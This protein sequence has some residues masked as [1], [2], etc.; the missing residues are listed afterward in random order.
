MT[1]SYSATLYGIKDG[2]KE[3]I[4]DSHKEEHFS[5]LVPASNY[6]GQLLWET[7]DKVLYGAVTTME[8]FKAV[9]KAIGK[10]DKPLTWTTPSNMSCYYAP[11]KM[12]SKAYTVMHNRKKSAY[13]MLEATPEIDGKK[14]TSSIA[15]NII[16][17]FD[18]S[19][20]VLTANL[21]LEKG[22]K[23]FAFVHD[24][25]GT[26][27]D[28]AQLLLDITKETF[29]QIYSQD[30]LT[31]LEE[32]FKLNYPEAEIPSVSEFVSYGSYTVD[33]VKESD[34]FFG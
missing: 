24:S 31:R 5:E 10:V 3:T 22:I 17:S 1:K 12:K 9:A 18:A 15:P 34:Y 32:E 16:H 2:V 21:C 28:D 26:H 14:L 33:S 11:R 7:M 29:I 25:F 4:L 23:D 8:W 20:L 27:P 19:H 30:H 6:M 13:R